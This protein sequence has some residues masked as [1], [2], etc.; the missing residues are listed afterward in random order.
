MKRSLPPLNGLRAFEAAA[1]HMSFTDAAEELSVTQAAISHQVRG[2]EQRLGLKLFVRRNRS[3][4]LS[5]AGQA[6]LPSVRAAFDQLNEATEK[7]LQK[8]KGGNLTVTTTSSF[9]VKW[10]VPRLGGFQRSHPEIDVRVSTGTSLVDFSREDVDIGIRYGRGQWPNLLAERLVSEDVMPVCAPSLLKGPNGLKKPVDLRRF[11]LLHIASFPDDWQVWLTA[12]G[13]KG[14]DSSR[15]VSFDFALAAYQAAMDGL[16]VAL[17]RNP[18]VEPDLKA[19]RLVVPFEFKRSSDFAY[20]LVYPPEAIRRRK[21]KA[22]RDWIVS[23]S[24]VAQQAV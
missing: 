9:A 14:V 8:D 24:D 6:Y 12:A 21:I 15:G 2:L 5:E 17:G 7:L 19:G 11:N 4:L 22:F 23:L 13:V 20:Y 1:R 16:G 10:L 3:L 18:L